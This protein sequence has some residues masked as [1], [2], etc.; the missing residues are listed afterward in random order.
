MSR[1]ELFVPMNGRMSPLASSQAA[2]N[3]SA[4]SMISWRSVSSSGV[5]SVEAKYRS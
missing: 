3:S 5:M 1:A 2:V 4:R